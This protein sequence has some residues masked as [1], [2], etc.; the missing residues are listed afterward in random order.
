[1]NCFGN[2]KYYFGNYPND[3]VQRLQ[4]TNGVTESD[5]KEAIKKLLKNAGRRIGGEKNVNDANDKVNT[6]SVD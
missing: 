3:S 2:K 5:V 1:M 6:T 4:Q